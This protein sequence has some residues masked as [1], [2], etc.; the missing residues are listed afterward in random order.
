MLYNYKGGKQPQDNFGSL[1][2][3]ET[4]LTTAWKNSVCYWFSNTEKYFWFFWT[5]EQRFIIFICYYKEK[6]T[7]ISTFDERQSLLRSAK[8]KWMPSPIYKHSSIPKVWL[9]ASFLELTT[10][11]IKKRNQQK[12]AYKWGVCSK[13]SPQKP[14]S[15]TISQK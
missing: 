7:N 5:V 1:L 2:G 4:T 9:A 13:I 15:P 3:G 14:T 8:W 12:N 6:K 11:S 10:H